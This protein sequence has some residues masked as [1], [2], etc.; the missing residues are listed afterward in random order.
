MRQVI[1]SEI[2]KVMLDQTDLKMDGAG[3]PTAIQQQ[4]IGK[5]TA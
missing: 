3:N 1:M 5:V 4:V 2:T